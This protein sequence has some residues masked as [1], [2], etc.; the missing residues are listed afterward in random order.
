MARVA[1]ADG[2]VTDTEVS[3]LR[4]VAE[5]VRLTP[6]HIDTGLAMA[7]MRHAC[8]EFA[9]PAGDVLC[10]T[11]SMRRP[12]SELEAE[13]DQRGFVVGRLPA[14]LAFWSPPLISPTAVCSL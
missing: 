2:V 9:L 3:D 7:P 12:R 11:G 5:C 10:L 8:A 1:L 13:L 4:L 14:A 6:N